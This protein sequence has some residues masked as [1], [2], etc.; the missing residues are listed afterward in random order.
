MKKNK[1]GL[2]IALMIV[3]F[4]A[5]SCRKTK[6]E[7]IKRP[8]SDIQHFAL[9]GYGDLD[10]INAVISGD[11]IVVYWNA[12]VASPTKIKPTITVSNG[13]TISPASGQEVN[14]SATTVYTV[15]AEDGTKREYKLKPVFNVAIPVLFNMPVAYRW[16]QTTPLTILGEYFFSTGDASSIKVYAQRVRD[17][18]E[19]DIPIDVTQTTAT[20]INARLPLM[21]AEL[22]TGMH[23]IYVKV[24][25]FAS[26]SM[27]VYLSRP[28]IYNDQLMISSATIAEP[29]QPLKPGDSLTIVWNVKGL[30]PEAFE[31]FYPQRNIVNLWLYMQNPAGNG[32]LVELASTDYV[33]SG[34]RIKVHLGNSFGMT[35]YFVRSIVI[36]RDGGGGESG[37][38]Y[39]YEVVGAEK[40][41]IHNA[42]GVIPDD[43]FETNGSA[44]LQFVQA[45]QEIR[46]GQELR[47]N[48][49]FSSEAVRSNYTG[50]IQSVELIF[51]NTR[52]GMIGGRYTSLVARET[53]HDGYI[54][55]SIPT[56]RQSTLANNALYGIRVVYTSNSSPVKYLYS[57]ITF[58]DLNTPFIRN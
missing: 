25:D 45:G 57:T 21:T 8:Y 35:G 27:E 16:G 56:N 52:T 23:R 39:T 4:F 31:R 19:F 44:T 28:S 15:T 37:S 46:A 20:Q 36:R 12:D 38:E 11:S 48:Y 9:A 24:G 6:Y 33:V 50:N 41:R 47:V 58:P 54:T 13:A 51:R 55:F 2:F 30:S 32:E 18:F 49:S 1:T 5:Q 7:Q 43:D 10:S 42:D 53:D 29:A 14:F 34:N 40:I 22:D 17:G 3:V 26:N